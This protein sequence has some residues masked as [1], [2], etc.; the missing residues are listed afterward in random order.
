M[1]YFCP[2]DAILSGALSFKEYKD[3]NIKRNWPLKMGFKLG[4][5]KSFFNRLPK[6]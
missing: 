6:I 2:Q 3:R 4:V 1:N 5:G